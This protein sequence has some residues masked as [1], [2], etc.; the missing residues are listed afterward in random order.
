MMWDT[1]LPLWLD[2]ALDDADVV[3]VL[4]DSPP[5]LF[6]VGDR[7]REVPAMEYTLIVA[8]IETEVYETS[9]VQLDMWTATIDQM[10]TLQNALRRLLHRD[11]AITLT[12]IRVLTQMTGG[13]PLVGANRDGAL[14]HSIDFRLQYLRGKYS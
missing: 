10:V 14:N 3:S 11:T 5:A 2:L 6:L 13:R 7:D 4:G 8:G 9:I 12:G 1:V